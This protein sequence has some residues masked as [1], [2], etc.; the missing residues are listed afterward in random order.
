MPRVHR[1]IL[2]RPIMH[3]IRKLPEWSKPLRHAACWIDGRR[4]PI[5]SRADDPSR[6]LRRPHANQFQ[7]LLMRGAGAEVSIVGNIDENLRSVA[8]ELADQMGNADS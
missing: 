5:V 4:D 2:R 8:G 3:H 1:L 6:V 7:V